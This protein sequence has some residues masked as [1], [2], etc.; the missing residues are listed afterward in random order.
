MAKCRRLYIGLTTD[1]ETRHRCIYYEF[2]FLYIDGPSPST[3]GSA[4]MSAFH[5]LSTHKP[6]L[7]I[8]MSSVEFLD[9]A[10]NA[11]PSFMTCMANT[12]LP[13]RPCCASGYHQC[14]SS[15]AHR[16]HASGH[17]Q[18]KNSQRHRCRGFG[19][20][21]KSESHQYDRPGLI[22]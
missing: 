9:P 14:R 12:S 16:S 15:R 2:L 7:V 18:C 21:Y 8:R 22:A 20:P 6:E 5:F 3:F 4:I 10:T 17:R 11:A 13:H 1:C 19:S